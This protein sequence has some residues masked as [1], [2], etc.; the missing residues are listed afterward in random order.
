LDSLIGGKNSIDPLGNEFSAQAIE[1]SKDYTDRCDRLMAKSTI[2]VV[3]RPR[4]TR[5]SP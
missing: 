2:F 5:G 4:R 3:F 1:I